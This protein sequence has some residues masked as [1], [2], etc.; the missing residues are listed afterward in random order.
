MAYFA[1]PSAL[2]RTVPT[3]RASTKLLPGPLRVGSDQ[4]LGVGRM[5]AIRVKCYSGSGTVSVG[6]CG[7]VLIE[8][9]LKGRP[10]PSGLVPPCAVSF[11]M[12]IMSPG[13]T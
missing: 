8:I 7:G 11:G 13:C 3:R 1:P 9:A 4:A 10:L 12:M 2:F 6:A 5:H